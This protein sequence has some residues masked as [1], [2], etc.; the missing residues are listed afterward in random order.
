MRQRTVDQLS[1]RDEGSLR[2]VELYGDLKEILRKDRYLF[3]LMPDGPVR[4]DRALLLN[5][6]FWGGA[7]GD[8]LEG[9]PV[10]ADIVTHA[11]WH[12]LASRAFASPSG[13]RPTIESLF[14]GESIASAF[15]LYL[16]GRL[17]AEAPRSSF[18]A[19]QVPAM[20]ETARAAGL[21]KDGFRRLLQDVAAAPERSFGALQALLFD[22]T[23]AL[24]A[25]RDA[26]EGLQVLVR[27]EAY[28]FAPL[29]HHYELSNW[30][31]FARARGRR[32][33]RPDRRV[34]AVSRALRASKMP[35]VWL[36][37]HWVAPALA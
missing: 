16:M 10:A 26:E 30:V 27:F 9:Q 8:V 23:L 36:A 14:L 1:I 22:V 32:G 24:A 17:V 33:P 31:L 4:W 28:R 15:D 7:G 29:L 11:A 2:R 25:C 35:L 18:L 12:H 13:A 19:T 37:T 5:L 20:A 21:S 6:T 3:R 34:Q